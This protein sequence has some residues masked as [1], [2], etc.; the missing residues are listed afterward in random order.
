MLTDEDIEDVKLLI[1]GTREPRPGMERHF[2][3][4]MKG[5]ACPCSEKE[6]EWFD[7]WRSFTQR[8]PEV[9]G[10]DLKYKYQ[11]ALELVRERER[12]IAALEQHI[13][14][15][16]RESERLA[17]V[18]AHKD[19]SNETLLNE[20]TELKTFLQTAHAALEKYEP[21]R[22]LRDEPA[23]QSAWESCH[24]CGGDGGAGGRCPRCGGN[25]FEPK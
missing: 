18:L 14:S 11:T 25:G 13:T 8:G 10:N 19:Q 4:V 5:L 1:R 22:K 6:A 2:V 9:T 3:Q 20:I 21:V 23:P 12:T 24:Q 16:K 15:L 17:Q 7:Y